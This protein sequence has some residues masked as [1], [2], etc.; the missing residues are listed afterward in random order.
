MNIR[1]LNY[2]LDRLTC[3]CLE[4]YLSEIKR[5]QAEII[6]QHPYC[7]MLELRAVNSR[8]DEISQQEEYAIAA[9]AFHRARMKENAPD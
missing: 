4:K 6:R 3:I 1:E 5:E 8:F 9:L 7:D 2:K